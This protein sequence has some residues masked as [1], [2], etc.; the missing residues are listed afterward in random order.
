MKILT[1]LKMRI[2]FLTSEPGAGVS[3]RNQAFDIAQQN[4]WWVDNRE[5]DLK[6]NFYIPL[7]KKSF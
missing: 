1:I 2:F 6:E 7:I 3:Q 5:Q 4:V